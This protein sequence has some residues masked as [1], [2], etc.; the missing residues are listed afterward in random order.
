VILLFHQWITCLLLLALEDWIVRLV[1]P[2]ASAMLRRSLKAT[3]LSAK[4]PLSPTRRL[5]TDPRKGAF[6]GKA[7]PVYELAPGFIG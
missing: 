3:P 2:S 6:M 5:T 7:L 4:R 1:Y